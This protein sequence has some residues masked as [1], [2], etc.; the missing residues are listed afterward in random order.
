MQLIDSHCHLDVAE[1]D[2]DR[3]EVMQ[4][5]RDA[6]ITDFI[7]PA[8][9]Q[10]HWQQLSELSEQYEGIHAAYGLHPMFMD[11]HRPEHL[12]QLDAWLDQHP[13]VAVGECGL[14]FYIPDH[15]VEAQI[16]LLEAQ[17]LI[18]RN[19]QL[20]VIIHC[21]RAMDQII[22]LLRK[23]APLQGVLHSFNGSRQQADQAM[24]LG[25]RFGIGGP[26][27]YER[28]QKMRA[29]VAELPRDS[30]LLETDAPDQP[31]SGHQ[32]AR[33]EP[34]LMTHVLK[35]V[36]DIRKE[37]PEEVARYTSSNARELFGI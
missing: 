9:D 1:F 29:L 32:G 31:V 3:D 6:G 26:I 18:A 21:R 27:T 37:T 16:A 17:L 24:A 2:E 15:D 10:P 25:F 36:A 11:V 20:P 4:R 30:L 33:N 12:A 35:A 19:Q 22:S 34:A 13:A 5:A 23:T 7:V 8:I 14:D 28:A